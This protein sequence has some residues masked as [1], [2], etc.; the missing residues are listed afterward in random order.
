MRLSG[1]GAGT[2]DRQQ[3]RH[4]RL[5]ASMGKIFHVLWPC[6][7]VGSSKEGYQGYQGYTHHAEPLQMHY[8]I[9]EYC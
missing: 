1:M 9:W 2:K 5:S 8:E 7:G 6:K 3:T 4:P